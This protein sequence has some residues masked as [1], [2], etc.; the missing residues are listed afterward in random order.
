MAQIPRAARTSAIVLLAGLTLACATRFSPDMVRREI[1]RQNEQDPLSVFELNLGRF[2][3]YML[4]NALA[5]DDADSPFA[6]IEGLQVAV[7]EA[8]VDQGPALD[9]TRIAVRGWEPVL[10]A[11]GPERSAMVLIRANDDYVA[12]LV[13]VGAGARKVVYARLRGA[14]SP[15]LPAALGEAL[16]DGGPDEVRRMLTELG[17]DESGI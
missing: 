5:V 8:P 15:D 7:Y 11:H 13:V 12:D 16:R 6:G 9:V 2:T 4:K 14:L 10:R 17:Q 3:T 1:V